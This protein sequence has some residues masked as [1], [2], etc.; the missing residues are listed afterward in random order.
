MK[1]WKMKKTRN[2]GVPIGAYTSQP[3][4]NLAVNRIDHAFKEQY[5]VK[6]LHRYCDDNVMLAKSKSEAQFL[7]RAYD[8]MSAEMGFV[9]KADSFAAPIEKENAP[10]EKRKRRKRKRGNRK[11]N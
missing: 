4:G 1:Y 7:L 3:L 9:V 5:R 2:R 6:C 10:H 11:K 8:R